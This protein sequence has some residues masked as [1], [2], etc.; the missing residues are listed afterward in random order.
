MAIINK[1][2]IMSILFVLPTVES[3]SGILTQVDLS[4]R[5]NYTDSQSVQRRLGKLERAVAKI[6]AKLF[7][8]QK[9]MCDNDW[10]KYDHSCYYFSEE[11][12]TASWRQALWQ[13]RNKGGY[14]AEINNADENDF[15]DE[16]AQLLGSEVS[17]QYIGCFKDT[18]DRDI[19]GSWEHWSDTTPQICVKRCF[20]KGFP[21]A[22][23]QYSSH[24]FCGSKYGKYGAIPESSC[25]MPCVGDKSLKCGGSWAN[26]VYKIESRG[27]PLWLGGTDILH[28][29]D[30]KWATSRSMISTESFHYWDPK[31]PRNGAIGDQH[32]L[33]ITPVT[34]WAGVACGAQ[35]KFVCE[36][37]IILVIK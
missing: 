34:G 20:S 3:T 5:N 30:W 31:K 32:C 9:D 6:I 7:G 10:I 18:G 36:K 12:E 28:K 2:S 33:L 21:Y 11:G 1:L 14:L 24:C 26:G 8:Q 35:H 15:I 29:G 22:A 27:K 4:S 17:G 37:K 19:T 25:Q 13:C 23:V 16:Q